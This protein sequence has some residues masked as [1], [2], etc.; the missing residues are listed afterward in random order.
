M[1]R[2]IL[3]RLGAIVLT[4]AAASFVIFA[5]TQLLPGDVAHMVLGEP[6]TPEAL[7]QVREKMGLNRPWLSRYFSWLGGVLQGDL[8]ESLMAPGSWSASN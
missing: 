3:K 6:A 8:G 1:F 7:E 5:I 2:Y 4:L